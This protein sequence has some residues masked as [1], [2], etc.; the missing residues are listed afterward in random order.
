M[1]VD[2]LV[3]RYRI[4][5]LVHELAVKNCLCS[6]QMKIKTIYAAEP[7]LLQDVKTSVATIY[8]TCLLSLLI[9]YSLQKAHAHFY[10]HNFISSIKLLCHFILAAFTS[11]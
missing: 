7:C 1:H 10:D 4:I 2:F 11:T 6:S 9:Q 5:L 8:P 3:P